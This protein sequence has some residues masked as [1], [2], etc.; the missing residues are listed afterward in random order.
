MTKWLDEIRSLGVFLIC[1]QMLIHF[2]PKGSYV[3]YLRLLVSLIILAQFIEPIGRIAGVLEK[4]QIERMMQQVEGRL[5]DCG[6][7]DLYMNE[8][9]ILENLLKTLPISDYEGATEG[10]EE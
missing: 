2:R 8:Q 4:G 10:T 9:T 7:V 3:K 5:Q 6:E 1:A